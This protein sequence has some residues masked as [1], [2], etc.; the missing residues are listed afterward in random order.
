MAVWKALVGHPLLFL[1]K[2]PDIAV[3]LTEA[4]PNLIVKQVD[5]GFQLQFSH[6]FEEE[7]FV[8]VKE[9]P[10]RYKLLTISEEQAQ[11]S[12]AFNGRALFVPEKGAD[13]LNAA[14]AGL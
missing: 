13:R 5:G 7:G 9:T 1:A 2:S 11:I 8:I 14:I 3:Q 4:Q 6:P 10:T 12:P